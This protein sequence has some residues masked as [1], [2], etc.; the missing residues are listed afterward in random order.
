MSIRE[1]L[2]GKQVG[3][4]STRS[5]LILFITEIIRNKHLRLIDVYECK[6]RLYLWLEITAEQVSV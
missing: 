1:F 3:L 4:Q 2:N 5:S 6:Q